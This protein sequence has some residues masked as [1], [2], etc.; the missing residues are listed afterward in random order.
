LPNR[1]TRSVMLRLLLVAIT[2]VFLVHV[3]SALVIATTAARTAEHELDERLS[4]ILQ[5]RAKIM[6]APLWKMQYENL[7]AMLLELVSDPVVVSG[8]VFDDSGAIV[9]VTNFTGDR[10]P[11]MSRSTLIIYQ[12]G[13]IQANAGRLEVALTRAPISGAFWSS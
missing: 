2:A 6:S 10:A 8:K 12:D 1:L 9:A 13:N 5:S 3:A 4:I 11:V 7:T